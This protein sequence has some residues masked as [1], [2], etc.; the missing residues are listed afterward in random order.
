MRGIMGAPL[1]RKSLQWALPLLAYHHN[2]PNRLA[3]STAK[4][5]TSMRGTR[6]ETGNCGC[7]SSRRRW[8][9][10]GYRPP[11]RETRGTSD[12]ISS[13]LHPRSCCE[14]HCCAIVVGF[15]D[16]GKRGFR[17][18]AQYLGSVPPQAVENRGMILA[19]HPASFRQ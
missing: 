3:R 2:G 15:A 14:P 12:T 18:C 1:G 11:L 10:I 16:F 19:G 6:I 9:N 8:L 4:P 5:C 7:P 13:S 17:R